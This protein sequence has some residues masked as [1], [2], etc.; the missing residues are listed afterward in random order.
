M[1][2]RLCKRRGEYP[3]GSIVD[4]PQA[5]AE[6]LIGFGLAQAVADVDAEAPTRLLERA[7][8]SKGMRTATISQ[9]EPSVAPEG[10]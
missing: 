8:V 7:K 3:S 1:L 5:E 4:L 9:S 10:E 2:V 6:S